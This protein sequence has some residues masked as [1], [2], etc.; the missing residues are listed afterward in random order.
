MPP[1]SA[2]SRTPCRTRTPADVPLTEKSGRPETLHAPAPA[3]EP[4]PSVAVREKASDARVRPSGRAPAVT[5]DAGPA[6]SS[7]T[8][9]TRARPAV[10]AT[11]RRAIRVAER[12][13]RACGR[14]AV[15]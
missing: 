2:C 1:R 8:G 12:L 3:L 4:Q 7:A 14:A 15:G 10:A 13:F 9:A 5:A 11:V 6:V